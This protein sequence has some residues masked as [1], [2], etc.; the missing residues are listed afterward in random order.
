MRT[1]RALVFDFNGTLSRDEPVLYAI[2]AELFAEHGRPLG[3]RDYY[4]RLAGNSEEAIIGGWLGVEGAQL[5]AL[6]TERIDRYVRVADGSTVPTA[7]REAVLH[8]AGLVD[9]IERVSQMEDELAPAVREDGLR[10]AADEIRVPVQCPEQ[11]D[12]V[13]Q[14][15]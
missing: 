10:F 15:G 2:Y 12:E 9:A 6:I 8:A 11:F 4:E 7:V 13:G 5:E 14:R 1:A 3:E